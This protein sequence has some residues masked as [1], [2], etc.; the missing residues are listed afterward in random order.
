M[1]SPEIERLVT[2]A[3]QV[4]AEDAMNRTDTTEQLQSLIEASGRDARRRR[5]QAVGALAAVVAAVVVA[6][7]V[8]W[9]GGDNGTAPPV[10]PPTK[11]EQVTDAEQVAE[12][13]M[14]ALATFDRARAATYVAAGAALE[15]G[16]IMGDDTRHDTW[17]LRNRWD[18]AT[19]WK[20]TRLEG[21]QETNARRS[22]A[23][24]RCGFSAHQLGSDQLGRG[25]FGDN[26]LAVTVRDGEIVDATLTTAHNTNRF[27]DT[28]WNPFWAWM[29]KAHP[30]DQPR[31]A[32]LEEPNAS[33]ARVNSSLRLWHQ[34]TQQ[35][36]H[37]VKAG[38]AR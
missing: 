23:Y 37:A 8:S 3:L 31:M 32:A 12:E 4:D 22:E 28:M 11:V 9:P 2:A 20:V 6:V 13:F 1:N 30:N 33:P 15:M 26:V 27:A 29:G 38:K 16:N 34:R 24:V 7:V 35:Y 25:P 18:E 17:T 21:C 36:V 5:S 10:G 14:R 19:G